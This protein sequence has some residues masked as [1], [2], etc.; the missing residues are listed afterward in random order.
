MTVLVRDEQD[1]IESNILFHKSQGVD[2]FVVTDNTSTDGTKHKLK[3][4]EEQGTLLY[5][6]EGGQDFDQAKWVTRMARIAVNQYSA[7]WVINS[8]ADEFWWPLEGDLRTTFRRLPTGSHSL[9]V[10][11]YDFVPVKGDSRPFWKKWSSGGLEEGQH[12]Y[13]CPRRFATEAIRQWWF[14]RGIIMLMGLALV[15]CVKND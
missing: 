14:N 5:L 6:F 2:F 12:L 7:D 4:F 10:P 13:R 3:V 8:D 15:L 1:I 9:R 11:V